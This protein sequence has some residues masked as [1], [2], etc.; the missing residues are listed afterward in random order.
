MRQMREGPAGT[1]SEDTSSGRPIRLLVVAGGRGVPSGDATLVSDRTVRLFAGYPARFDTTLTVLRA[2]SATD[3]PSELGGLESA[4]PQGIKVTWLPSYADSREFLRVM[5]STAAVLAR[6]IRHADLV[7]V[8]MPI[9]HSVLALALARL[10]RTPTVALAVGSWTD[11]VRPGA[12]GSVRRAAANVLTN[13]SVRLST[14]YLVH[15]DGLARDVSPRLRHRVVRVIQ[16]PLVDADFGPFA[17]RG[18]SEPTLL[19]AAR[20]IRTKRIGVAIRTVA[21]LRHS[22]V[23][24]MLEIAGDGP[25]RGALERLAKELDVADAVAFLGYLAREDLRAAYRRAFALMLPSESE[26]LSSAALEAM[27][28]GTVV[29]STP[30]GG[31]GTFLHDDEDSIVVPRSDPDLFAGAIAQLLS[32]PDHRDRIARRAQDRVRCITNPGW[33]DRLLGIARELLAG[34]GRQRFD[35]RGS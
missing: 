22:G 29:V 13:L 24:V 18:A 17:Y 35:G 1:R 31:M 27:A 30:A 9:L 10:F 4:L 12:G 26:G 32:D 8:R 7:F 33:A 11:A 23:Q 21:A 20:L 34:A 6:S 25:E 19:C 14:R 15:G 2:R 16:S 5:P 3:N 28:A